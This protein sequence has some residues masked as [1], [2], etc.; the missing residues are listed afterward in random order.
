MGTPGNPRWAS[1][2]GHEKIKRVGEKRL[3]Q[4]P[5][6]LWSAGG[7]GRTA[8]VVIGYTCDQVSLPMLR[9]GLA[10]CVFWR[11]TQR[12][13]LQDGRRPPR[14]HH[15]FFVFFHCFTLQTSRWP[16]CVFKLDASRQLP[17]PTSSDGM[18]IWNCS[19]C[20]SPRWP[21]WAS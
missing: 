8:I 16:Q 12:P 5:T 7:L 13:V 10:I 15:Q 19:R 11:I 21:F 1:G 17:V 3:S 4:R 20:R 14:S 6:A 9:G 18:V 2:P